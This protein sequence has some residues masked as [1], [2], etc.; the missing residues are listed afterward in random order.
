MDEQRLRVRFCLL[1]QS[2]GRERQLDEHPVRWS[3]GNRPCGSHFE[4]RAVCAHRGNV[5]HAPSRRPLIV[6]FDEECHVEADPRT[7]RL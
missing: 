6:A 3:W 5:Q 1:A 7:V 4:P 2:G